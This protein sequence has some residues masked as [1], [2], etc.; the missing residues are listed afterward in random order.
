MTYRGAGGSIP[1]QLD[2]LRPHRVS[3]FKQSCL[4]IREWRQRAEE[5]T[6]IVGERLPLPPPFRCG[7]LGRALAVSYYFC[8][9]GGGLRW[10]LVLYTEVDRV[11]TQSVWYSLLCSLVC[12]VQAGLRKSHMEDLTPCCDSRLINPNIVL[13]RWYW[14]L[15]TWGWCAWHHPWLLNLCHLRSLRILGEVLI[16]SNQSVG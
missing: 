14:G 9:W 8:R 13:S 16:S 6:R 15:E 1:G 2:V 3:V 7:T 10:H 5:D 12:K 11:Q 4:A